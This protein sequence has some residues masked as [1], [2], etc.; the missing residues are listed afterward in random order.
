MVGKAC[1][2]NGERKHVQ[3]HGG[4]TLSKK[5]HLEDTGV[6][7]RIILKWVLKEIGSEVVDWTD[8]PRI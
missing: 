8:L 3:P 6:D 5:Q 1:S 7:G 2:I 4:E